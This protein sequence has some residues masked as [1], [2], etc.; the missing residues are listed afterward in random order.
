M[1]RFFSSS[2]YDISHWAQGQKLLDYHLEQSKTRPSLIIDAGANI[3]ASAVF[4]SQIYPNA[5]IFT[6]EPDVM[7]WHLLEMNTAGL[8][9]F[10]F[11]GAIADVDGELVFQDPGRSDWGFMTKPLT[12]ADQDS[13][14]RRVKSICP[15]SILKHAST[16][17]TNPLILKIDIEGGEGALFQGDTSWLQQFPLVIIELHDWMLPFAGSSRNFLKAIAQYDF[18]FVHKGENIFLFNRNILNS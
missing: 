16:Q 4:F 1:G 8:N 18:D 12:N 5:F 9:V 3:G 2:I 11:H 14:A 7:N 15:A 10:N 6:I 13:C 17:N